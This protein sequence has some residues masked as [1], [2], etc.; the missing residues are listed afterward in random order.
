M[1]VRFV[2]IRDSLDLRYVPPQ[3]WAVLD[4]CGSSFCLCSY[5]RIL[6][7]SPRP[8]AASRCTSCR[9]CCLR[10]PGYSDGDCFACLELVSGSRASVSAGF[11]LQRGFCRSVPPPSS[12]NTSSRFGLVVKAA[13]EIE[14]ATR[15]AE[16]NGRLVNPGTH[17]QFH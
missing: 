1:P 8:V 12:L 11:W 7:W 14:N 6:F 4:L 17:D 5:S 16:H 2:E 10:S 9:A 3:N 15:H 13:R